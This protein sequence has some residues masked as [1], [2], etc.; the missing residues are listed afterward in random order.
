MADHVLYFPS[1]RVPQGE[2]FVRV[3]LYWDSVGT[4]VPAEYLDDPDFLRPYTAELIEHQLL[5]AI[6]PDAAIWNSG[7]HNYARAF[8]ELVDQHPRLKSETPL[9]ERPTTSVHTDKTGTG[10]ALA[11]QERGLARHRAGP[12]WASWFEVEIQTANLLM[13]YLAA[14]LARA[15]EQHTDPI[16]DS[17]DCLAAFTYF[18]SSDSSHG[19]SKGVVTETEPLRTHILRRLLPAPS[20]IIHAYDI[21]EFKQRHGK[22]LKDFRLAVEQKVIAVAAIPDPHL[23]EYQLDLVADEL[24]QQMDEIIARM[25]D[26]HWPRIALGALGVVAGGLALADAVTTGGVLT[27]TAASLGLIPAAWSAFEGVEIPRELLERPM[28]YAALTHRDLT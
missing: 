11:L 10:L 21:A 18:H 1:I 9:A 3:L 22:L 17:Q 20:E 4:I 26:W 12:E 5:K 14:I 27:A 15:S 19:A 8:L 13:A 25:Q 28:A 2:W 16:T 24:K 23:R 7:A 6:T